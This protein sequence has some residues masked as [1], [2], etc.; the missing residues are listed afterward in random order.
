MIDQTENCHR[1]LGRSVPM[2]TKVQGKEEKKDPDITT[3]G[4]VEHS[5]GSRLHHLTL[6]K[7]AS[8]HHANLPLEM[9]SFTL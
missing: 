5:R 8:N 6:C 7:K 9:Y 4:I 2:I 3:S 1:P